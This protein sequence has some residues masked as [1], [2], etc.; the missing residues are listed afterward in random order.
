[1]I[2][3]CEFDVVIIGAGVIGLAVARE[4]SEVYENVLLVEKEKSFGQHTSSRNSEIIHSGIYYPKKTLKTKMCIEGNKLMYQFLEKYNIPHKKCGK[5]IV[6]TNR[7]EEEVLEQLYQRGI[8]NGVEALTML[9]KKGIKKLEPNIK[10][11]KAIHVPITGIVD[12]HLVML[13]L[14]RISQQ[15]GVLSVYN[16]EISEIK[17]KNDIYELTTTGEDVIIQTKIVVNAAGLWSDKIAKMVGID[18]YKIYWCKGE[19]YQTN[20]YKNMNMLIYPTPDPNG[21]SLGIHTVLDLNG[22][23]SFGPNAYYVNEVK[24]GIGEENRVQFHAAINSYLDLDL[25]DLYPA[26]AGIRPKLQ[27][28]DSL[29]KD[30]VIKNEDDLGYNNF[31]NLIGIESPGL[32]GCLSIA[33]YVREIIK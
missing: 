20:K 29:F 2:E 33:K 6:A 18:K 9:D 22:N 21:K 10:A 19:Y 27:E 26:H 15:N 23:L 30:F 28:K 32:T 16:T 11:T 8:E 12:S 3:T 24:Y 17:L 13:N 25:C 7:K 4:L 1:M 14:K 5:L 31:I